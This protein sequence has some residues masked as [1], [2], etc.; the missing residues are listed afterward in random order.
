VSDF[1]PD[2]LFEVDDLDL[3]DTIDVPVEVL[4]LDGVDVPD[5]FPHASPGGIAALAAAAS[6]AE[7]AVKLARNLKAKGG[8]K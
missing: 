2:D 8:R 7:R 3:V 4:V 5:T 1:M 6:L